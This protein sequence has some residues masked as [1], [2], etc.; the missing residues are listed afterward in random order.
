M[1]RNITCEEISL[2]A[3][4]FFRVFLEKRAAFQVPTGSICFRPFKTDPQPLRTDS[5]TGCHSSGATL[6]AIR[7]WASSTSVLSRVLLG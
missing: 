6:V 5:G 3:Q 2:Y 4:E 1:N 7:R